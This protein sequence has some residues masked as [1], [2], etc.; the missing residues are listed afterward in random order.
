[1][2]KKDID[3]KEF[4][5]RV[6]RL[7]DFFISKKIEDTGKDGS[8]DLKVLEDLKNDAATIQFE[9]KPKTFDG[10]DNYMKGFPNE[11]RS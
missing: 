6:E 2:S 5:I 9:W 4:A 7:C 11:V 10:L 1:V 8:E 3:I